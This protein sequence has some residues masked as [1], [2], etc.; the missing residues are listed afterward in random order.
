MLVPAAIENVI[1]GGTAPLVRAKLVAEAA[2]G[3]TTPE[4]DRILGERG[5]PVI[6]DV[7]LNAGGVVV[8]YFEWARNLSHM[9]FGLLEKRLEIAN[10]NALLNAAETLSGR[11]LS[12]EMRQNLVTQSDEKE[13]VV[14]GLEEKMTRAYDE[15][16]EA[17]VRLPECGTLRNAAYVVALEKIRRSAGDA[18]EETGASRRSSL[19]FGRNTLG[20]V[21]PS[22]LA[23][24]SRAPHRPRRSRQ[25]P[26]TRGQSDAAQFSRWGL[27]PRAPCQPGASPLFSAL[28]SL[29]PNV[30]R[31]HR[32]ALGM[33][34]ANQLT[35]LRLLLAPVVVICILYGRF[36]LALSALLVAGLTDMIDGPLARRLGENSDL[37]ALLDPLADKVLIVSAVVTLA[38]PIEAVS[39]RIPA[40][41]AI[42]V[43]S[44][45]ATILF[46]AGAYNVAVQRRKFTP[47]RLGKAAT[48][49]NVV[50]ILWFLVANLFQ[51]DSVVTPLLLAAMV[52]LTA[53]TSLQYLWRVRML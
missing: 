32:G 18:Y 11:R 4:G 16:R 1:H 44:R 33:T 41:V 51:L 6:P 49:I 19:R 31:N 36:G 23:R 47:S 15:I 7:Y 2:N 39:V 29:C 17:R 13:L 8:S 34:L 28:T 26:T 42:L 21:L 53:I 45:D 20:P 48:V 5:I 9:R 24:L 10:T 52:T 37:G 46:V 38:A 25:P 14:S 50:G 30:A 27:L 3:P 40:W 22:S 35:V 12:P 43:L